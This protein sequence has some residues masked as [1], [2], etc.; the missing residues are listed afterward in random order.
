MGYLTKLRLF[1]VALSFALLFSVLTGAGANVHAEGNTN[2]P[3]VTESAEIAN[4]AE[5]QKGA[6]FRSIYGL[7]Q[8]PETGQRINAEVTNNDSLQ[9]YGV[10]LTD[11]EYQ[12]LKLRKDVANEARKLRKN[13]ILKKY[14]SIFSDLYL[15][16]KD[17]G[18][19]KIGIVDLPHNL[20]KAEEI[21]KGFST[22][23]RVEFFNTTASIEELQEIQKKLDEFVKNKKAPVEYTEISVEENKVIAGVSSDNEK[24]VSTI[25]SLSPHITVVVASVS[26]S[27][28]ARTTYTRPL[29]AGLSIGTCTGAFAAKKWG[30]TTDTYYY[31]TAGHC[32]AIGSSWSQG[33]F[34]IGTIQ[35]RNYGGNTDMAGIQIS[36]SNASYYLY[37]TCSTCVPT[38]KKEIGGAQIDPGDDMV[39][40][41]V[42]MS[43]MVS[44]WRCGTIVSK[45][46]NPTNW[47]GTGVDFTNLRRANY[48]EASG[49]SGSPI[50]NLGD[51][52]YYIYEYQADRKSVV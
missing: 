35:V 37:E 47:A 50:V 30:S 46:Y 20:D 45:T 38:R 42:C 29:V 51:S 24:W 3:E 1:L 18:V 28:S 39:G 27:D 14:S 15:D 19:I 5:L 48:T 8:N 43:G 10:I 41:S 25:K 36:S 52:S 40:D 17:G 32:G 49:D 31:L 4:T 26:E 23:D 33:G 16:H 9:Q 7:D 44:D 34:S 13:V 6:D 12:E 22:K 11:A 21:K 2:L